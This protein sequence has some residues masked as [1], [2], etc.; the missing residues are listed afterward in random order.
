MFIDFVYLANIEV[1]V[2]MLHLSINADF[3][4]FADEKCE[5]IGS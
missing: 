1:A 4:A 5:V 3:T 2:I